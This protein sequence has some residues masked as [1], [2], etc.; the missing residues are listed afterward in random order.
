MILQKVISFKLISVDFPVSKSI[1]SWGRYWN[2]SIKTCPRFSPSY[3]FSSSLQ[4][5][6][7]PAVLTACLYS[8]KTRLSIWWAAAY[9]VIYHQMHTL[10][11]LAD[12]SL[13]SLLSEHSL[14]ILSVTSTSCSFWY[15]VSSRCN[16]LPTESSLAPDLDVRPLKWCDRGLWW[17]PMSSTAVFLFRFQRNVLDLTLQW[18]FARLPNN[19]KLEMVPVSC[20]RVGIGNT[21]R[22]LQTVTWFNVQSCWMWSCQI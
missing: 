18:R 19:A 13:T 20:N 10:C 2:P 7:L 1:H 21:V 14:R 12:I 3:T 8:V 4:D 22:S 9:L 17:L 6:L 15:A 11:D 16:S 5:P